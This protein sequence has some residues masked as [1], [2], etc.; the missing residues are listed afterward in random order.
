MHKSEGFT[1]VELMI[2]V[3]IGGILI[4]IGVGAMKG[5]SFMPHKESCL[6]QGGKYTEGMQYG[7][8]TQLCTYN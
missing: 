3:V 4:A 5:Q 1:L 6:S 2:T 7:R 8:Y